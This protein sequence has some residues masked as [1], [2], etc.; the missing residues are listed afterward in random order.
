VE[1]FGYDV[2]RAA[3]GLEA[4]EAVKKT[5]FDAIFMDRHMPEMDGYMATQCIRELEGERRHTPII[6][7]TA[8]ALDTAKQECLD[9]G[10]DDF[11]SKP[12]SMPNVEAALE[13]W[14]GKV[15]RVSTDNPPKTAFSEGSA[16]ML[17]DKETLTTLKKMK[18]GDLLKQL[19]ETFSADTPSILSD[20]K[21]AINDNKGKEIKLHAHKL[22]GSAASLGAPSMAEICKNLETMG[23]E[24]NFTMS[25]NL[26]HK[27]QAEFIKVKEALYAEWQ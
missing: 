12:I 13:R 9:A 23:L 5:R 16:A 27:L 14:V 6:A 20:I 25:T 3:N 2:Q 21:T 1:Q 17:L 8:N 11:I 22:K 19:I 10:M 26:L 24:E 4:L 15:S 18:N 7:Q